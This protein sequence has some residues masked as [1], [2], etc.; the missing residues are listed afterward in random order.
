MRWKFAASA[1]LLIWSLVEILPLRDRPVCD[2]ALSLAGGDAAAVS[3]VRRAAAA[4]ELAGESFPSALLRLANGET[5]DLAAIF[6]KLHIGKSGSL[7]ERNGSAVSALCAKARG[8]LRQGLD[9]RG[10]LSIT[11]E[12]EPKALAADPLERRQQLRRVEDVVRRR[13]DAMGLAEPLIQARGDNQV[14]LQ[15]AGVFGGDSPNLLEAVKKPAKLEFRMPYDGNRGSSTKAPPG[16]TFVPW[17]NS[18]GDD[19]AAG[20]VALRRVPEL[21]GRD[22]KRAVATVNQYGG[23]EIGLEMT[24][25]GAKKFEKTTSANVGKRLAI[26][27]DGRIFSMP[28]IRSPIGDGRASISGKFTQKEA[29]ELAGVLNNPLE[30]ELRVAEIHEL[31]PSL[32]SDVRSKAIGAACWGC[33]LL[34]LFMVAYYAG[35]G[36]V[37]VLSVALN[38]LILLG[39]MAMLGATVTIPA[40]AALALI[41]G[42]AVD[43]NILIYSRIGEELD[44]G[45][46]VGQALSSGFRR[47]FATIFDANITTL[48]AAAILIAYGVGAV[49]GF[50]IVLA[51]GVLATLFCSIVFCGGLLDLFVHRFAAGRLLFPRH[52]ARRPCNFPFV[53][54]ARPAVVVGLVAIAVSVGAIFLK[55]NAIYGIDFTG[56]DELLVAFSEKPSVV[57]LHEIASE[58]GISEIQTSFHRRG[59]GGDELL[60]VRTEARAG[61]KFFQLAAEKMAK[62]ELRLLRMASIGGNVSDAVRRNALISFVLVIGVIFA[63]VS[64]R[65]EFGF[66]I[67]AALALLHDA[68]VTIGVYVLLGHRLSAPM[69][70]AILMVVGYSINDTIVVFDRIREELGRNEALSLA[71]VVNLSIN[72][73]LSRTILTSLTVLIASASMWL[74]GAG[75]MVDIALIFT[76]GVVVGT[77]SSIFIASPI[78]IR[79]YGGDRNRLGRRRKESLRQ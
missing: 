66:A 72:R 78:T 10:G 62:S 36:I 6:R 44:G 75:V 16:Y 8:S 73:T 47:A 20:A 41:V 19:P 51:A 23:Y 32:A 59:A 12:V 45:K 35:G 48:L 46:T 40:I 33:L 21:M 3:V 50:G 42:M 43:S 37:A 79:W 13:I 54:L 28:L 5:I 56:G 71:Q 31:G 60:S 15:L 58:G 25:E 14:E 53:S 30:F 76:I 52:T 29:V 77:F 68:I 11:F 2:V 69:V 65:F 24:A 9:L 17:A 70:A 18:G 63:Y 7:D 38:V 4:A 1:F 49:R 26:V 61:E 74:L 67:G 64:V 55:G 57:Q 39:A 34:M 22:I 27:L